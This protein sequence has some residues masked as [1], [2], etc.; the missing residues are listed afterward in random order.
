MAANYIK[1][2]FNIKIRLH[3][4]QGGKNL[5][6]YLHRP[7]IFDQKGPLIDSTGQG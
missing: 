6:V 1:A 2:A 5:P 3:K 4:M 7:V